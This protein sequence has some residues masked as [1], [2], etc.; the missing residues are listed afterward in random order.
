M[1]VF[2][3][4][5]EDIA[6]QYQ[7]LDFFPWQLAGQQYR[8]PVL[9]IHVISRRYL[10]KT[11]AEFD[12]YWVRRGWAAQAPVKTASRIDRPQ[13]FAEVP[14][15]DATIAGVAWA[16]GRGIRTVEVRVDDGSWQRA[17]LLPTPST[18][19]WVQWRLPWK[20]AAGPHTLTVRATDDT[21]AVQPEARVTPF[22]SGAT[23]WHGITVTVT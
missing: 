22:P 21:G 6:V 15:G 13:P 17:D 5:N 16:Q 8:I 12:A 19:T 3:L 23:G 9:F 4:G 11:F 7:C 10:R 14:A 1:G 2:A 18:D 20:P